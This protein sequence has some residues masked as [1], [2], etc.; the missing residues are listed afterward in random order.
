MNIGILICYIITYTTFSIYT[1]LAVYSSIR[2]IIIRKT[3]HIFLFGA[4][5]SWGIYLYILQ[6]ICLIARDVI[7]Q[8]KYTTFS[9]QILVLTIGLAVCSIVGD[10][11]FISSA[12]YYVKLEED[13]MIVHSIW[14]SKKILYKNQLNL[15]K[16]FEVVCDNMYELI[17][18]VFCFDDKYYILNLNC[19]V[20]EYELS[21]FLDWIQIKK[22]KVTDKQYF[23][24]FK[25][26]NKYTYLGSKFI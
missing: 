23:K 10:I 8:H 16:S 12:N 14:F 4:V 5:Y 24:E 22:I 9:D 7:I 17:Y 13:K 20:N 15:K 11:C 18:Y 19:F 25:K 3:K 1:I 6:A 26:N 21:L 2:F